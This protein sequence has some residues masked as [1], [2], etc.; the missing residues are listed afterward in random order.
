MYGP[1]YK[2]QW[3]VLYILVAVVATVVAIGARRQWSNLAMRRRFRRGRRGELEAEK[4]LRA[5]GF[6]VLDDQ[7][8]RKAHM[9]V[10][11]RRENYFVRA[12][13]L[14]SR[15]WKT[16]VVEVKTGA[17]APNPKA[18][19]TRRQLLEYS[20]VYDAD[21]LILA[22]METRTLLEIRFPARTS[23]VGVGRIAVTA[24][25]VGALV[26]WPLHRFM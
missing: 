1:I 14:V 10:N 25:V 23:R 22:D 8:T 5:R 21:G 15:W 12:D 9:F 18:S 7:A 16:Y 19:A 2:L 3:S 17:M 24:F 13:F 20:Q 4:L 6:S 11:G 26:G